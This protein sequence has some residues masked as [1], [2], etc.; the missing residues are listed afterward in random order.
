MTAVT[1]TIWKF[2]L[3]ITGVQAV[4]MPKGAKILTVQMQHDE[5]C[6]WAIVNPDVE[7]QKRLFRVIGTGHPIES[8]G[9]EALEYIGSVQQSD[10]FVWHLYEVT[11][12]VIATA[13]EE[14]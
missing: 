8:K 12:R 5:M 6:I 3:K 2:P 7:K 9:I 13:L 10:L 4:E 11:S 14:K 1:Y